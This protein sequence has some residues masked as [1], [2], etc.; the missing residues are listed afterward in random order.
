MAGRIDYGNDHFHQSL[1]VAKRVY[2]ELGMEGLILQKA[3]D[4]VAE[5][6]ERGIVEDAVQAAEQ[7]L[8]SR[9]AIKIASG[10]VYIEDSHTA[11]AFLHVLGMPFEVFLG[12]ALLGQ[13]S[14]VA[15]EHTVADTHAG[16]AL[17]WVLWPIEATM[18]ALW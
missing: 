18:W 12:V 10:A 17:F 2:G 4:F 5:D 1:F 13:R 15:P 11:D 16:G 7:L 6:F 3:G 14:P 8:L 9:G